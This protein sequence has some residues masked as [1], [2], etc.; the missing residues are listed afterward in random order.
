MPWISFGPRFKI[1]C[2]SRDSLTFATSCVKPACQTGW[3]GLY[4]SA[5]LL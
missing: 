5:Q 1:I 2:T 3:L 4:R